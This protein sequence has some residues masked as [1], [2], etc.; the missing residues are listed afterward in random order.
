MEDFIIWF[1]S[2]IFNN[3]YIYKYFYFIYRAIYFDGDISLRKIDYHII[4]AEGE[5]M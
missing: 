4:L 3:V 5:K 1:Y 2:F